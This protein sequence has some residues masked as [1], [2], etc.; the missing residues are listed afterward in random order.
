MATLLALAEA[1]T[2]AGLRKGLFKRGPA[3]IA[4]AEKAL[5]LVES[6]LAG[7]RRDLPRF[8][9]CISRC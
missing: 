8:R 3:D 5:Q 2:G 6:C 1:I 9:Y 7:S 4:L